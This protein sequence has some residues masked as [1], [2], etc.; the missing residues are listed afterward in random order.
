MRRET[1][2]LIEELASWL[3][4][5]LKHESPSN[6]LSSSLYVPVGGEGIPGCYFRGQWSRWDGHR[7]MLSNRLS[8]DLAQTSYERLAGWNSFVTCIHPRVS[9]IATQLALHITDPRTSEITQSICQDLMD[10]CCEVEFADLVTPLFAVPKVLP[11]YRAGR[12][13]VDWDGPT[14]DTNWSS[15]GEEL[16]KG[17]IM[18]V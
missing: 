11:V 15:S 4:L 17:R 8:H 18:Y 13:P 10:A 1:E 7:L 12:L 14:I 5:T 16:P 2:I 6:A 9:E 3:P